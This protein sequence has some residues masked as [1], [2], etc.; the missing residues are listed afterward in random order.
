MGMS[1][2]TDRSPAAMG[3]ALS[4]MYLLDRVHLVTGTASD[5]VRRSAP[6]RAVSGSHLGLPPIAPLPASAQ[7]RPTAR[8]GGHN[9]PSCL[10]R[11]AP[12]PRLRPR[13]RWRRLCRVPR[14][15]VLKNS[16][17]SDDTHP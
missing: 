5:V 11:I 14:P 8:Y 2:V 3:G 12:Y 4:A 6:L 9:R 15:I 17:V 1:T 13:H 16:R 10:R 7:Y